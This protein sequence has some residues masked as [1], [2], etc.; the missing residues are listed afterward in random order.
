M[1]FYH[2][3]SGWTGV[4]ENY[5]EFYTIKTTN[6]IKILSYIFLYVTFLILAHFVYAFFV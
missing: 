4:P 5:L 2:F 1:E 3:L 6:Q